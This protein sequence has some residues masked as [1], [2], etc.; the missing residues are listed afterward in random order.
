[1]DAADLLGPGEVG[2]CASDPQHTVKTPG[3]KPHRRGGFRQQLASGLVWRCDLIKQL[4]IGFG[5]STDAI[6]VVAACL[7][8]SCVRY[9]PRDFGAAL[10]RRGQGQIGGGDPRDLDMQIDPIQ[11]RPGYTRLIIGRAPRRPAAGE[12]WV[13]KMPATAGVHRRHQLHAR[14]ESHVSVGAG[15]TDAAR[16]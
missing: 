15:D 11:Q 7:L 8:F 12:R 2:N 9:A 5:I 4:T 3:R 6:P 14:G 16:F 10:R 13:T 1:M